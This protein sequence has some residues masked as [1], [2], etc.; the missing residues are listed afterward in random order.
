[1]RSVVVTGASK[2]LGLTIAQNLAGKGFQVIAV[3][4]SQSDVL[5]MTLES[6]VHPGCFIPF[7]FSNLTELDGLAKNIIASSSGVYALINN[8]AMGLS[9]MLVTAKPAQIDTLVRVN[10]LA[11]MLLTRAILRSMMS[12]SEGR[13]V[14]IT[15]INAFTG[16]SGLAAY[17]ATKAGL[18]GFTKS[19]AREVGKASITVNAVAAG[20]LDTDMTSSLGEEKRQKILRRSPL[21]RFATTDEVSGAVSYLLSD[22]ALSV[23]GTTIT[24]DAGNSV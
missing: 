17:A 22:E 20:F 15:S 16:Y 18:I 2:G 3:S 19:L 1:M 9:G 6:A 23:T 8:A 14:N 10:L 4:R 13:I 24:I 5:R 12:A 21:G 7:D 11:P